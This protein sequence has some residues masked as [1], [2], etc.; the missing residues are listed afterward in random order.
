MTS[1]ENPV[2]AP[3]RRRMAGYTPL[4]TEHTDGES[5]AEEQAHAPL[6]Q[7]QL[8]GS[9]AEKAMMPVPV[10]D[11]SSLV[12]KAQAEEM[13]VPADAGAQEREERESATDHAPARK[14][15]MGS[16]SPAAGEKEV[17]APS[18][19]S[20]GAAQA[21]LVTPTA[22]ASS[23]TRLGGTKGGARGVTVNRS[24]VAS[25]AWRKP[26][27]ITAFLLVLGLL[28]VLGARWLRT[29]AGVQDFLMAYD[30]HAW[31]PAVAPE[32]IPPWL[33]WQH[34][35]N[36]FFIVLI[37]RTGLQVRTERKP[38]GY[39]TAKKDSFFSPKG[40]SP[41]KV[42]L[43]Q[44]LHQ[45]LDVLWVANG[46]IFVVL[47]FVSGQWMRIVPMSWDV[48]PNMLSAAIQY[49]SLD[50]PAENGWLHYN[51]LQVMAYFLT[52]FVAAPLAVL[53]GVRIST[54]WPERA[55]RLTK[56]YPVGWARALHFPV[57]HY[58]VAFTVV[59]VFLVFFTGALRNL[60]HIYGSRDI[61]DWWGLAIFLV[62]VLA[63]AAAWFLTRP[64]FTTPIAA[65]LGKVT[66]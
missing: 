44:W 38:P 63:I 6:P 11:V 15:R 26:A 48:F 39:W 1:D 58:F 10:R 37:I 33:G 12:V 9:V 22:T 57:M 23:S 36:V 2:H 61:V 19:T 14:R 51:A 41:K 28:V 21:E 27:V 7:Q 42:S 50:W 47:L 34:F 62:S 8:G 29:L 24:T 52:V 18:N 55:K 35:L 5:V 66:K 65:R 32:G 43:S 59:H 31:Q 4:A 17:E 64:L 30:G 16:A 60:N 49:A 13:D 46:I 25:S 54:W 20:A 56:L 3:K 45:S 40:N 53:T